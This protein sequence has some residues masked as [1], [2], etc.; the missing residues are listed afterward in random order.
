[1][2]LLDDIEE[3]VR[4]LNE[5]AADVPASRRVALK[6]RVDELV[7]KLRVTAKAL[8]PVQVPSHFFDPSDPRLV[9]RFVGLALVAQPKVALGEI[10][11]VYGSGVYALYYHGSFRAYA[12][13]SNAEHPIYVG[14]ADPADGAATTP[15]GQGARL[16]G[17]IRDHQRSIEK[18][19]NLELD[20]FRCRYLVVQSGW[21]TAAES[22]LIKLFRPI[23]NSEEGIAFGVGKHGDSSS[24]R[25]N[26]RS[27]W[28][29]LHPGRSWAW[30]DPCIEDQVPQCEIIKKITAHFKEVPPL[31]SIDLI[32][33]R[34]FDS[35]RQDG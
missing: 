34:F 22:H 15:Q 32:L 19:E 18:A 5:S 11:R 26:K 17:R 1:M 14:K 31:A 24:T 16:H 29:T 30:S 35:L 27:P 13:I 9:G 28:D 12:P 7:E 3:L 33:K 20:D 8:D 21:Q 23:W 6:R 2:T 4:E 10:E 25:A